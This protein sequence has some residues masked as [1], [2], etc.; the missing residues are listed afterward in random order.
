MKMKSFG[1]TE[2]QS[3]IFTGYL[4]MGDG[5]GVSSEPPEL[6]WIRHHVVILKEVARGTLP[7]P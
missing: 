5:E 1:F 6:L 7:N 4:K 2:T 3:S